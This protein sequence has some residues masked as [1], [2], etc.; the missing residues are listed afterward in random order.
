MFYVLLF[1]QVLFLVPYFIAL[2]WFTHGL[3]WFHA[4]PQ[5]RAKV[6][7]AIHLNLYPIPL[8]I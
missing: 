3:V 4:F 8:R 5:L 2:V 7:V 6:K 1:L